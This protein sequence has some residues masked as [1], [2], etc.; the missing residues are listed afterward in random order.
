MSPRTVL[1][2]ANR[3]GIDLVVPRAADID[4]TVLAEHLSKEN[5]Y[6]GATPNVAYSVAEHSVRGADAIIAETAD[7]T[8]AAYFL[9]HD[10][11]EAFLKDDTTPKKQALAEIAH[12]SF[13][14]LA[15]QVMAVFDEL[16]ERFDVAI[17]AAADLPWPPPPET[18]AKI[19]HW[20]VRMFVTE[21]RD[22]MGSLPHPNWQPYD[23]VI[24]L[25]GRII[26]WVWRDARNAFIDECYDLLPA[27]QRSAA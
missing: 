5:R 16:T 12:L 22:L 21:W 2:L 24:P 19:K 25:S 20:D 11:A 18:K 13:G 10:G 26:P 15:A 23:D 17:H 14:I 4:F 1:T 8:L 6:N 9:L 7:R 3:T 27:L